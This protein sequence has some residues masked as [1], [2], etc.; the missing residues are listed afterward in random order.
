MKKEE[1]WLLKE[2]YSGK[3]TKKFYADVKRLNAGE[4]LDYVIGFTEFLG[5]KI[6]LSQKPLIPRPETEF[7]VEN[8]LQDICQLAVK[9]SSV[10]CLDL[11]SG[12]GCIGVA[13][14][15]KTAVLLC[16]PAG[17]QATFDFADSD[18]RCLEQIK[19]N[20]K[21]NNIDKK[22][23]KIIKSD[24]FNN[25]KNK[26]DFILANPPYI[27]TKN[28]KKVQKSVLK[29]EPKKALFGGADGMF[30]INKFLKQAKKYL[31][32]G[33]IIYMEFDGS[34]GSP[35]VS[36][37]KGA[38]EKLLRTLRRGSGRF[39]GTEY[40]NF[41]FKKDQYGKYRWVVIS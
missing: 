25:I 39:C 8:A 23:Y 14:L 28:K 17:R 30:Y 15:A 2:K 35:Q 4:P 20:C 24:L 7:W 1:Q 12:S 19:I 26:Y 9:K 27:P 38:I 10:R 5:C 32:P 22:R 33:G 16:L 18:K 13:V 36:P 40:S 37:Q 21:I 29:Y 6:D 41:E 34:A 11:F 3:A 31:N